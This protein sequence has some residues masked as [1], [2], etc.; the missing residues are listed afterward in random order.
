MDGIGVH[1]VITERNLAGA[2]KRVVVLSTFPA[3]S[4]IS[5]RDSGT[6]EFIASSPSIRL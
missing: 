3:D 6:S 1:A 4:V 2:V 5:E